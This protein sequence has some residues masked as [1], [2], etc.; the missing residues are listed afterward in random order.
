MLMSL[1]LISLIG[2]SMAFICM[3]IRLPRIIGMLATG[4]VLGPYVL[5]FLDPKSS[6]SL[7]S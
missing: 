1:S 4:V 2:L 6:A 7:R 3:K 5:N